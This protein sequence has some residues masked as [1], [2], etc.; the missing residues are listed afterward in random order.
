MVGIQATKIFLDH[1]VNLVQQL[2]VVNFEYAHDH[3]RGLWW[4]YGWKEVG[5]FDL[6]EIQ[7]S[8]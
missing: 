2:N 7:T 1:M 5:E 3:N 4:H 6:I 8:I